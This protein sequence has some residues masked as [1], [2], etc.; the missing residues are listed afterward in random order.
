MLVLFLFETTQAP[1][2]ILGTVIRFIISNAAFF[3]PLAHTPFSHHHYHCLLVWLSLDT[4][5][6]FYLTIQIPFP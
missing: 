6:T 3:S 4:A 2:A 1:V 5:S